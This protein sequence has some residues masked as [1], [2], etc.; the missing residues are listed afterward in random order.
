MKRLRLSR[1]KDEDITHLEPPWETVR[2]AVWDWHP[3]TFR[4]TDGGSHLC[5]KT[6]EILRFE[7][8]KNHQSWNPDISWFSISEYIASNIPWVSQLLFVRSLFTRMCSKS[9]PHRKGWFQSRFSPRSPLWWCETCPT[10]TPSR[11][12]HETQ[13]WWETLCHL[14]WDLKYQKDDMPST[15]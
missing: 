10:S 7:K 14:P 11:C 6:A 5:W 9:R 15:N 2:F 1:L 3:T 8:L 12:C 4:S 13:L